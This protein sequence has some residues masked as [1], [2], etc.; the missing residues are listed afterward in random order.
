MYEDILP[1]DLR[2]VRNLPVS[3]WIHR[4]IW[5]CTR[6]ERVWQRLRVHERAVEELEW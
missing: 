2:D 4:K 6:H 1:D 3:S 5:L